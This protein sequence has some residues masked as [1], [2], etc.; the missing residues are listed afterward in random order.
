MQM[1]WSIKRTT[2]NIARISIAA[3]Q[4]ERVASAVEDVAISAS[5]KNIVQVL[6]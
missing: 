5:S 3:A 2:G 1:N 4:G 6:D